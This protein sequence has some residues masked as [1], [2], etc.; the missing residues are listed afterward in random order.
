MGTNEDTA[1]PSR[2]VWT[3]ISAASQ[4]VSQWVCQYVSSGFT[5]QLTMYELKMFL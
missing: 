3:L 5:Q 1:V 4:S 2:N